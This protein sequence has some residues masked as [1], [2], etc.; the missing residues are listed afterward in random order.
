MEV[1]T[2]ETEQVNAIKRFFATNGKYLAVGLFLGIG[3]LVG[4]NYWQNHQTN[5]LHETAAEFDKLNQSLITDPAANIASVE[6][7]ANQTN[8]IYGVMAEFELAKNAIEKNDLAQAEKSLL[9]ASGKV[10]DENIQALANLRLSRVQLAEDKT[11]AALKTLEQVKGKSWQVI[12]E[13][14]RGDALAK[15]GDLAGARAAYSKGLGY[16]GSPRVKDLIQ[17]KLNDLSN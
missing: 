17:M 10:K 1:Y 3:A 9:I 7:F 14:I 6:N 4:W 13:D 16:D 15:K 12:V 11:D 5:R 8:N 2:T